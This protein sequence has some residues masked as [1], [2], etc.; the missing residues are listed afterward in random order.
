MCGSEQS[1]SVS[2]NLEENFRNIKT[3]LYS[4][5]KSCKKQLNLN[6]S[7][8]AFLSVWVFH[9]L[10]GKKALMVVGSGGRLFLARKTPLNKVSPQKPD[11]SMFSQGHALEAQRSPNSK[12]L[13]SPVV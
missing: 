6:F 10:L 1:S 12:S 7:P 2:Y 8:R 9:P 3:G 11:C 13:S 4:Q 5:P